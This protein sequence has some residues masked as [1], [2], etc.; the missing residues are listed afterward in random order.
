M[1]VDFSRFE[2][3]TTSVGKD[4]ESYLLATVSSIIRNISNFNWTIFVQKPLSP[5][6]HSV[7]IEIGKL[8]G[9]KIHI[10]DVDY[11]LSVGNIKATFIEEYNGNR[12]Y[13]INIDDDFIFSDFTVKAINRGVIDKIVYTYGFFDITNN[14]KYADWDNIIR[15]E[16]NLNE[17][18]E[19]YGL[20]A[21]PY[22]LWKNCYKVVQTNFATGSYIIKIHELKNNEI[23][24]VW[25]SFKKGIRGYDAAI[26]QYFPEIFHI[27]SASIF[28]IG[29]DDD[30]FNDRFFDSSI[31]VSQ[32]S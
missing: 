14:R 9:N 22:H 24:E 26:K 20:R 8:S 30:R 16:R 19:K 23:L 21:V 4:R 32:N 10:M 18:V 2:G 1:T 25:K 29:V 13:I 5:N 11:S 7:I 27:L 31:Y 17:I 3:I 15:N 6:I 28:H 12:K